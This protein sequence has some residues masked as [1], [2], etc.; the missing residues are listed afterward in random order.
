VKADTAADDLRFAR[1]ETRT[2]SRLYPRLAESVAED[3]EL[4]SLL[5]HV[6][7][8]E[9]PAAEPHFL[10]SLDGRPLA[11]C[12]PQGRWLQWLA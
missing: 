3:D 6:P 8:S 10:I 7:P 9:P 12:D 1:Q 5:E 2:K 11:F 4:L